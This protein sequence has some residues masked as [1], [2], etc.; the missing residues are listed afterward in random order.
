MSNAENEQALRQII[1]LMRKISVVLLLLHFYFFCYGA[2]EQWNLTAP[3]AERILRAFTRMGLFGNIHISKLTISG[4]LFLSLFGSRG[5]KD[6]KIKKSG[7]ILY[8]F[9][10]VL[11]FF[12]STLLFYVRGNV[13]HLAV[14]YI[15]IT[16]TGYLFLLAGG[17][18]LTRFIRLS[19]RNDIFNEE[20]ETFPQEER[21][22]TN[23]F[24]V[25]FKAK[26][27]YQGRWRSSYIS[28][29]NPHKATLIAGLPGTGKTAYLIREVIK[30]SIEKSHTLLCYDYK[31]DDLTKIVYN[32][33]LKNQHRY[34]VSPQFCVINFDD[35]SRSHRCNPLDPQMMDDITDAAEAS[36]SILL[37]LNREFTKKSGDFFV[38]SA[39]NFVTAVIWFLRQ[40]ENGKYC[41]LPHVVEIISTDYD[42]LFAVLQTEETLS[43]YL[44]PFVNAWR[45]G[46]LEQLEGQISSARIG[47]ARPSSPQLYY[48]LSG[49]DFS[50]DINNPNEP[51]LLCLGNNP[52]KLQT[53]GAVLS[54][55]TNRLL[56]LVNR[57]KQM[58]CTLLFEEYPTIFQPLD[59]VV[60]VGRSQLLSTWIVCQSLEQLRKDYSR[61][62]ADV[63]LN[64]CGNIIAGQST[65]ETA[66]VISERIGKIVQVR[67]SVSIN[68]Q[69]TSV[70]K[71]TQ[72][73]YA[74]PAARISN[75]STGEFVG[76]L[77]DTPSQPMPLKS[78][79]AHIEV[80]FAAMKAEEDQYEQIPVIREVDDSIFNNNYIQIRNEC[81]DI[82]ATTLERIKNDPALAHLLIARNTD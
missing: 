10:G 68:R 35:P 44:G 70:S 64:I 4:V 79:H 30:Q 63:L 45:N 20:N 47:M 48:V 59:H 41:T 54:L 38:E 58:P 31:Y 2:F 49:N 22:L 39:I 37:G 14:G 61:E 57:K 19:L 55:Y 66:K 18:R 82:I 28:V 13:V 62:Q 74:V 9:F 78:F 76:V 51:K 26:Y 34:K 23:P 56:K 32:E 33:L 52:L 46:A 69:D 77:A 24:S 6:E 53:Y 12:G 36:R 1:D 7:I 65:G 8:L 71:S 15:A 17:A 75:L 80:D 25:N 5:K 11:I 27:K 40:Y 67:E 81:V 73:D 16:A 29:V 50:L 3:I 21:L 43:A 42:A 60:A 72:L